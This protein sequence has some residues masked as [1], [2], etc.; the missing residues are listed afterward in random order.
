MNII[1]LTDTDFSFLC[2]FSEDACEYWDYDFS[3]ERWDER[4]S[5][6]LSQVEIE[7]LRENCKRILKATDGCQGEL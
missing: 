1:D 3:I 7:Q 2:E 5:Q 6:S 4:Y